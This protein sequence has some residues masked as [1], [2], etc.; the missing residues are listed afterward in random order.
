MKKRGNDLAV[1]FYLAA[2]LFLVNSVIIFIVMAGATQSKAALPQNLVKETAG[3][4]RPSFIQQFFQ[5]NEKKNTEMSDDEESDVEVGDEEE[6]EKD[7]NVDE[8]EEQDSQIEDEQDEENNQQTAPVNNTS[9][10]TEVPESVEG[11][12]I[13][14]KFGTGI[15]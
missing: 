14:F 10:D 9:S 4:M 5:S 6:I 11:K 3:E 8:D 1:L 13:K 7:S 12:T 15:A 2:M